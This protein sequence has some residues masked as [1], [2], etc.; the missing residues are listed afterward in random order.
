MRKLIIATLA[1][2]LFS[3][4]TMAPHYE[5]PAAPVA[6]G[7]GNVTATGDTGSAVA[8][9]IGWRD[10]FTDP[11]LQT[12][13]EHAL[14]NNRDLRVA[15]L[16]VEAARAQY[17]IQRAQ[18][19]PTINV[20]GTSTSQRF[21][22]GQA[23]GAANGGI[24]RAQNV[25]VG[26]TSYELD[27]FGRVRSLKRAAL[28][29]YLAREET[30]RGAQISLV[31]EVAS[32][33]LNLLADQAFVQLTQE[34]LDNRQASH[35]I[36]RQR[37]EAGSAG[38]LD[39]RQAEIALETARSDLEQYRRQVELD[40][41]ALSVLIGG[42][43]IE[44][45]AQ[46][47]CALDFVIPLPSG[48]PSEVLT[49]RPDV[50]A[51]EHQLLAANADIGAA[52]AAF[53]PRI[54]L[55]G[56]YGTTSR[57]LSG[58][59][60]SGSK[61]WSFVPQITL[62]IFNGGANTAGLDLAKVQKNVNIAQYEKAIQIAFREVADGLIAHQSYAEQA[63]ALDRLLDASNDSAKIA[64]MRFENG[65]DGYLSVLDAQ[66]SQYEAQIAQAT[67]K[68]ERLRTQVTLY[69]ALGG[70]LLERSDAAATGDTSR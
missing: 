13:I 3:A 50:L 68:L 57:E 51:A 66:R 2:A 35:E 22:Q 63:K 24:I 5:R 65:I 41:N 56:S 69:K 60:D 28:E 55:T 67:I 70:G 30:Q 34:T 53:F 45:S 4:C 59:F 23:I 37:F 64:Q 26:V 27:L 18:L 11:Q 1:S 31:S 19:L 7:W 12:L 14:L 42:P 10:F 33:Y 52:R 58:L 48:L 20:T 61:V 46:D 15:T 29:D 47:F 8:A 17:Q 36:A 39:L 9:D 62:P 6:G 32:A 25:S 49:R 21:A 44:L 38:A 16:N 43:M 40:R 54:A